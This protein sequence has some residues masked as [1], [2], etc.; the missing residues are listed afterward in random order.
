VTV[1]DTG[2]LAFHFSATAN[3]DYVLQTRTNLGQG[4]WTLLQDFSSAPA[5]R[6]VWVTNNVSAVSPRFYRLVVGP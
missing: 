4:N 3:L 1:V 2:K 6:S 5:D